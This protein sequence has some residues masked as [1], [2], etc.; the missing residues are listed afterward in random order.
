M[1]PMSM[2]TLSTQSSKLR[3]HLSNAS[4]QKSEVHFTAHGISSER[5]TLGSI[6]LLA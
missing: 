2:L 6:D 4:P 3:A 5:L 1:Q